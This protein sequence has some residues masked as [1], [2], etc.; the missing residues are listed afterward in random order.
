M[1]III[2]IALNVE[3]QTL[4]FPRN[5]YQND[6]A[7]AMIVTQQG[8]NQFVLKYLKDCGKIIGRS[9]PDQI[10]SVNLGVTSLDLQLTD[11]FVSEF[12]VNKL[13]Q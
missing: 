7:L 11:I 13:M 8:F 1:I 4:Q 5:L 12:D 6:S 9:F 3:C 10:F 2:N